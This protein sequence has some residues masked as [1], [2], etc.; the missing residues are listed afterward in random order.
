[1]TCASFLQKEELP[2]NHQ[3]LGLLWAEVVKATGFKDSRVVNKS[4]QIYTNINHI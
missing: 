1:M 3:Q 4:S 2:N